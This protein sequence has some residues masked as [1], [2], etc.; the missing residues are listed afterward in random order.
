[1]NRW[2]MGP[3]K[4]TNL[5]EPSSFLDCKFE[6]GTLVC[7][8]GFSDVVRHEDGGVIIMAKNKD[9]YGFVILG[10]PQLRDAITRDTSSVL[11]I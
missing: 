11:S 4:P 2:V 1:M 8:E 6:V 3:E 10:V 5:A 7:P 9:F